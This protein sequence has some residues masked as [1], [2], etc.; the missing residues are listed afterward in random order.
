[1]AKVN[2]IEFFEK[3][4]DTSEESLSIPF[5]YP[6]FKMFIFKYQTEVPLP[7][8]PPGPNYKTPPS[9]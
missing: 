8:L 5:D 9:D 4:R 3:V 6:I 2:K 1:M 7:P